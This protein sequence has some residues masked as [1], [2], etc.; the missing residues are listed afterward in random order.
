[1]IFVGIAIGLVIG[2]GLG[3]AISRYE[4]KKYDATALSFAHEHGITPAEAERIIGQQ[5]RLDAM[6]AASALRRSRSR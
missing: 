1:M 4:P 2:I 6:V 3:F 5:R